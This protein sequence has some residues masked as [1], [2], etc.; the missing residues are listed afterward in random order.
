MTNRTCFRCGQSLEATSDNFYREKSRPLGLSYE[1]K[2][3]HRERKK[4]RDRR[5]E[6]WAALTPEQ[7]ELRR[8]RM[9]RWSRT[10]R[11]RATHLRKAY[12]RV[13]ACNL[14]ADEILEYIVQPC[15]YCGTT[16]KNRGLDRIDNSLPHIKGNVQTAC[17]DCNVMRGDRFTVQEMKLIGKTVALIRAARDSLHAVT[18]NEDHQEMT[19]SAP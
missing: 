6:R 10:Q 14:T 3:C 4:G 1:C 8:Q 16:T 12:Q 11:G 5:K 18:Q 15:V 2:E 19:G 17:T 13:D 7:K 9:L